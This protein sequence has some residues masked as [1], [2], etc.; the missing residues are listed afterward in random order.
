MIRVYTDGGC[1]GN[2]GPGAWAY[3]ILTPEGR[4]Q[5]TGFQ[6]LT[7]NNVMELTAAV[8][9]LEYLR[10]SGTREAL[11]VYTDSQYLMRGMTEWLPRWKQKHWKT[12]SGEPVRH[13]ELWERLDSLQL[14]LRPTWVWVRG[15]R[16]H[17]ENEY[18]DRLVN[19]TLDT[20]LSLP[21]RSAKR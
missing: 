7:T 1:R 2:P 21:S 9:A 16:G 20:Y 17:P 3:L 8:E 12:S 13:R 15:H 10:C 6:P 5:D 14:S 11:Q 18:C 4:H 19:Q